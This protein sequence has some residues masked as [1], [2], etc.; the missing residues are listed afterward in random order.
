MWCTDNNLT[1]NINKTK[2]LIIDFRKKQIVHTPL[3]INREIAERVSSFTFLGTHNSEDL[4]WTTDTPALVKQA[5][6][7]L[8]FLRMLRRINSI[9]VYQIMH[10]ETHEQLLS[11]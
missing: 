1:L 10:N 5:H 4:S 2:E 7:R 8:Y 6:K 9:Q 11:R 3:H